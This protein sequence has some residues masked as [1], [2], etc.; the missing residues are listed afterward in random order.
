MS[1]ISDFFG[2]IADT[3]G[4]GV[5]GLWNKF[6]IHA[7]EKAFGWVLETFEYLFLGLYTV[8]LPFILGLYDIS[9][10]IGNSFLRFCESHFYSANLSLNFLYYLIGLPLLF[11]I[12]RIVLKLLNAGVSAVRG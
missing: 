7:G 3:I 6:I 2:D 12:M 4:S 9:V 11:L 5:S 1:G 10:S 8:L